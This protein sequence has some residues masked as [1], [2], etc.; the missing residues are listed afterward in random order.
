MTNNGVLQ[1]ASMREACSEAE[2]RA[3]V[4]LAACY[5][6]IEIYGMADMMANHISVRVPGEDN[7]FLI[8]PYGMMYEEMTASC[9]IKVD[10]DGNTR[11][12]ATES[13][14][15]R[16]AAGGVRHPRTHNAR[17]RRPPP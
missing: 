2:W 16:T 4:D 3:R 8:N 12:I 10:L 17:I 7:A 14:V 11:A 6:L 5:R 13:F 15:S 1:I 9:L